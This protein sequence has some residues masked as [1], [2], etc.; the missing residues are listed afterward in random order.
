MEDKI[1][2]TK[3]IENWVLI[4][5]DELYSWAFYKTSSKETAE[6]LV[7]ETF[8]S[9]F[10][11][12]EKFENRSQPK[13]WLMAILNNKIID[14]YRKSAKTSF[15]SSEDNCSILSNK[16]FNKNNAWID[17]TIS[18]LWNFD[19]NHNNDEFLENQLKNCLEELPVKWNL[20]ITYKYLNNKKA[21]EICQELEITLT[22]Y[23]Q[24][25][26]RAKLLLKKCVETKWSI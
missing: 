26:H 18:D 24:I 7:Q 9:S 17:H 3:I 19:Q 25:V 13:T 4:Y 21:E 20:A 8:I 16:M 6:D 15:I 11:S 12:F 5:S 14:Y 10:K 22:N 1:N 23:W 2:K